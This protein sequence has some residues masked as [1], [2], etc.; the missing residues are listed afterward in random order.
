MAET[1]QT[2]IRDP[3]EITWP[4]EFPLSK[5]VEAHGEQVQVLILR[6]PTG[7]DVI[8]FGLLEGFDA[9]QFVPLV[10]RLAAVPTPTIARIPASDV[11]R[12]GTVLS[13]FFVWA[14]L[15]PTPSTTVSA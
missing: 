10:T 5:P 14:A 8:D 6:E 2:P 11:L 4:L 15:P 1:M 7:K 12:L 13:R 9:D 3:R